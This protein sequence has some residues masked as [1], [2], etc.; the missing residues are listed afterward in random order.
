MT[1]KQIAEWTLIVTIMAAIA[2]LLNNSKSKAQVDI[3]RN[4]QSV[5][6]L[7][8]GDHSPI[9]V[10]QQITVK[11]DNLNTAQTQQLETQLKSLK[12]YQQPFSDRPKIGVVEPRVTFV[13]YIDN[14]PHFTGLVKAG[15]SVPLLNIG[16]VAAKN[17]ITRWKIYDNGRYI[18]SASEYLGSDPYAI[19]SLPP[20][21]AKSLYYNPDICAAGVGTFELS[22]EIEYTNPNTGEKYTEQFKGITDYLTKQDGKPVTRTLTRQ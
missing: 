4:T 11:V 7:S 19:D 2:G 13:N 10:N 17:V 22:L 16:G 8:S 21:A 15:I 5:G 9:T 3:S 6:N 1:M 14:P 18:T 20:G 12:V